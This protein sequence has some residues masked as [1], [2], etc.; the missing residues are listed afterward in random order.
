MI[1]FELQ[2]GVR[3]YDNDREMDKRGRSCG[4]KSLKRVITLPCDFVPNVL[5]L[6]FGKGGTDGDTIL[7]QRFEVEGTEWREREGKLVV[8]SQVH[9]HASSYERAW[10]RLPE[11]GWEVTD[12]PELS[13]SRSTE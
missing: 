5:D 12:H 7:A 3:L 9:W 6:L 8:V 13:P 11:F 2:V 1:T 4:A 10:V